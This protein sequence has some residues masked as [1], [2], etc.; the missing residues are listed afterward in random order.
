MGIHDKEEGFKH[1]YN[2]SRVDGKPVGWCFV[3]DERDPNIPPA[4]RAYADSC[5]ARGYA[6]LAVDLRAKADQLEA[7]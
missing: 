1:K 7:N 2:V 4:L 5:E 3:L 6:A